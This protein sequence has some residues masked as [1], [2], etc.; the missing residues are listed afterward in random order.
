MTQIT[1]KTN[2]KF[3]PLRTLYLAASMLVVIGIGVAVESAAMQWAGFVIIAILILGMVKREEDRNSGLTIADARR[4]LD[5]LER[6]E[7]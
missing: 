7:Q 6:A 5:E 1:I 3:R 2:P 4:R